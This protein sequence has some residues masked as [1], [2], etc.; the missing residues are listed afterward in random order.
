MYV[1]DLAGVVCC[2][3]PV[4]DGGSGAGLER[5]FGDWRRLRGRD[6]VRLCGQGLSPGMATRHAWRRAA[7]QGGAPTKTLIQMGS[8]RLG[9]FGSSILALWSWGWVGAGRQAG[10]GRG[11]LARPIALSLEVGIG[12]VWYA[13]SA[14][15]AKWGF[16]GERRRQGREKPRISK[17]RF[18]LRVFGHPGLASW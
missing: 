10:R 18:A 2:D 9:L 1:V 16:L 12:F 17:P 5:R 8:A 6:I 14:D 3:S 13:G 11:P 4:G 15:L 7:R